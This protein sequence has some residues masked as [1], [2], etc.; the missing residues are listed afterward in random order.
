M[1]KLLIGLLIVAAGTGAFFLLRKK[2][3]A[4]VTTGLNKEWIV[5]QWKTDAVM[6]NDSNFSKYRFDFQK[7]GN[8]VRSLNDS[9][10]ADTAHYEWSKTNELVW[11]EKTS[12]SV[13][14]N[15]A[16]VKLTRDS[17][18]V[19]GKDSVVILFTKLK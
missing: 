13:G 3:D 10:K 9:A 2:K 5:G 18:Q 6:S 14:K 4:T 11:K 12:D 19:Q 1:N 8:L 16:V 15:F 17:L 7:D